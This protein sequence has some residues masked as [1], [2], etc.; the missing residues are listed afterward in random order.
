MPKK[1]IDDEDLAR[2]AAPDGL[3]N[4][5]TPDPKSLEEDAWLSQLED[6]PQESVDAIVSTKLTSARLE[7]YRTSKQITDLIS[8]RTQLD[9][10]CV[11]LQR[12]L[13]R[14]R[15]RHAQLTARYRS[16][17]A[18]DAFSMGLQLFGGIG[19]SASFALPT[20]WQSA[21]IMSGISVCI[22]GVGLAVVNWV[23]HPEV[24]ESERD[25]P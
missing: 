13:D 9:G 14:I 11:D 23:V 16:A 3:K 5:A 4:A 22:C 18:F 25:E 24:D 20:A 8:Q 19:V 15:P 7:G 10:R 21:G 2:V 17:R 6:L 12:T 1:K